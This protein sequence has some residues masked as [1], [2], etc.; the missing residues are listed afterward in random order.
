MLV[1]E[2]LP[3]LAE[4]AVAPQ[5]LQR[6]LRGWSQRWAHASILMGIRCAWAPI[7]RV[8]PAQ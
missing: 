8:D 3:P 5:C 4:S 2:D 1:G 7:R 6:W